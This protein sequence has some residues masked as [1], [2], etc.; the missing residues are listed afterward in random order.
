[1]L[2]KFVKEIGHQYQKTFE[3]L[4]NQIDAIVRDYEESSNDLLREATTSQVTKNTEDKNSEI[5]SDEEDEDED[6]IDWAN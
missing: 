3:D 1:M 2:S 4:E 5:S 6:E